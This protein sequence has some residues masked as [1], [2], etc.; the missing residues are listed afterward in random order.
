MPDIE[1]ILKDAIAKEREEWYYLWKGTRKVTS[2]QY[3]AEARFSTDEALLVLVSEMKN[4]REKILQYE[5]QK[6]AQVKYK[7]TEMLDQ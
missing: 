4:L 1:D 7:P 3:V 5:S 2:T 6:Q